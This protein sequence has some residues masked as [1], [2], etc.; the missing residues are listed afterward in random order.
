MYV[1]VIMF[2]DRNR[3]ARLVYDATSDLM[4]LFATNLLNIYIAIEEKNILI[5]HTILIGKNILKVIQKTIS[6]LL[7]DICGSCR[8]GGFWGLKQ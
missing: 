2:S 6:W 7:R 4:T 8:E 1:H 5:V 3:L